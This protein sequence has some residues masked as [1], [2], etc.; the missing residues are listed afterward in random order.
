MNLFKSSGDLPDPDHDSLPADEDDVL[1]RLAKK[2]VERGMSVPAIVFLESVKPLNFIA[3]QVMVFFEPIVQTIFNF[4]DY[5]TLRS[6]L[7]KRQS[8][9]I[10]L[11]KIEKYDAVA[12]AREKRIKKYMKGIKK[13]WAWYQKYL[14]LFR[15]KV[16]IPD[17]ILNP[18][19]PDSQSDRSETK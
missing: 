13:D 3:S 5:N 8:L 6:A 2:A 7:E 4:R 1:D 14:G 10:L 16:K 18:P 12:L 17:E 19:P 15:P 9:E 11:L